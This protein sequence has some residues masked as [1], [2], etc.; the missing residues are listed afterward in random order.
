[1]NIMGPHIHQESVT[2]LQLVQENSKP[3]LFSYVRL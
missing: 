1:M 2:L 3:Q